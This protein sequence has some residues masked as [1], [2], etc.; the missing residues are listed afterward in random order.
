MFDHSVVRTRLQPA[1]SEPAYRADA[2]IR[3]PPADPDLFTQ[4]RTILATSRQNGLPI[5]YLG[6]M[7]LFDG[8][9]VYSGDRR[10]W[11][12]MPIQADP[13]H[14]DRDGFPIPK[15][16]LKDLRMI[17]RSE[18]DFDALYIAHEVPMGT[19]REDRAIP[20]GLL[21]PP[22]PRAMQRLSGYLGLTS[23]AL[24]MLATLPIAASAAIGGV[25]NRGALNLGVTVGLDPI[26]LGV[27]VGHNRPVRSQEP[28]AWF[29]LGHWTYNEEV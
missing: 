1:L 14:D 10:D 29:Y 19:V 20:R 11:V 4:G 5:R 22:A 7:P 26:L 28:A 24:W 17:R 9:R 27:L 15:R 6:T 18:I 25:L 8:H 13:L 21:T 23:S 12:L 16:V 2:L 3:R